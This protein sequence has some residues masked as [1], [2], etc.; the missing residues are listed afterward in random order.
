MDFYQ[1]HFTCPTCKSWCTA[2]S[3]SSPPDHIFS[4]RCAQQN[5]TAHQRL[6]YRCLLCP[7]GGKT[8]TC[9]YSDRFRSN[10]SLTRCHQHYL[11]NIHSPNLQPLPQPAFLSHSNVNTTEQSPS[12]VSLTSMSSNIGIATTNDHNINIDSAQSDSENTAFDGMNIECQ[13]L[14]FGNSS[15]L[16][17]SCTDDQSQDSCNDQNVHFDQSD[18][19]SN[20]AFDDMNIEC[21]GVHFENNSDLNNSC[22]HGASHESCPDSDALHRTYQKVKVSYENNECFQDE[23]AFFEHLKEHTT[24]AT[25]KDV[26]DVYPQLHE[27]HKLRYMEYN[28]HGKNTGSQFMISNSFSRHGND[29]FQILEPVQSLFHVLLSK[30][31]NDLTISQRVNFMAL[32]QYMITEE[33]LGNIPD[34]GTNSLENYWAPGP[35]SILNSLPTPEFLY[36]DSDTGYIYQGIGNLIE[37]LFST[38]HAPKPFVRMSNSFHANSPR[39]NE[40]LV[41]VNDSQRLET[42][43]NNFYNVE[44]TLWADGFAPSNYNSASVHVCLVT[45]GVQEGDHTGRN[46]YILWLGPANQS[47]ISVE[48]QLMAELNNLQQ[49]LKANGVPFRVYHKPSQRIV[50]VRVCLFA[51]LCDKPDKAKR[52]QMLAGGS[53]FHLRHGIMGNFHTE[54]DRIVPCIDCYATLTTIP[55]Q[56]NPDSST[57]NGIHECNKC[58]C[59]NIHRMD[60]EVSEEYPTKFPD[61]CPDRCKPVQGRLK[62]RELTWLNGVMDQT[63]QTAFDGY[64]HSNWTIGEFQMFLRTHCINAEYTSLI[65]DHASNAKELLKV[66]DGTSVVHAGVRERTLASFETNPSYFDVPKAPPLQR[67]G[68]FDLKDFPSGIGHQLFLGVMKSMCKSLLPRFVGAMKSKKAF[69]NELNRKLVAFALPKFQDFPCQDS[70]RDLSFSSYLCKHWVTLCRFSKFFFHHAPTKVPSPEDVALTKKSALPKDETPFRQYNHPQIENWLLRRGVPQKYIPNK[71]AGRRSLFLNWTNNPS[72]LFAKIHVVDDN[73]DFMSD[74]H[75]SAYDKFVNNDC[76]DSFTAQFNAYVNTHTIHPPDLYETVSDDIKPSMLADVISSYLALISR[77]MGPSGD[78]ADPIERYSKIFL[79]KAHELDIFLTPSSSKHKGTL[80]RQPNYLSILN[81]AGEVRRFGH[82]RF[83]WEL[84]GGGEGYIKRIKYKITTLGPNFAKLAATSVMND[85]AFSDIIENLL[86]NEVIANQMLDYSNAEQ[87]SRKL[88]SR[89]QVSHK[90]FD[91][92][93]DNVLEHCPSNG[94]GASA[95]HLKDELLSS[96]GSQLLDSEGNLVKQYSTREV[97]TFFGFK[98]EITSVL[99]HIQTEQ[100]FLVE[101]NTRNKVLSLVEID[102]IKEQSSMLFRFGACYFQVPN[103]PASTTVV[104]KDCSYKCGDFVAGIAFQYDRERSSDLFYFVRRDWTE[105]TFNEQHNCHLHQDNQIGFYNPSTLDVLKKSTVGVTQFQN[106][107]V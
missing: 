88:S 24:I 2:T 41:D 82:L 94:L 9:S 106:E 27:E 43:G 92:A 37:Y 7:I 64:V 59:F 39:G 100:V 54:I 36:E 105:L 5:C 60:F 91:A 65:L 30:F 96:T 61:C 58:K 85:V 78:K 71:P 48:E 31:S 34:H 74:A 81:L 10:H 95:V 75:H 19:D 16:N 63:I 103:K 89:E 104:D 49:G 13:R 35:K 40:L 45:I 3:S 90:L 22:S 52:T 53:T 42:A 1:N 56:D 87:V 20:A 8:L 28:H 77:V 50:H 62:F 107:T 46:T 15:D 80:C 18:N 93:Q 12:L 25:V 21:P 99:I 101:H 55:H 72:D 97:L 51:F 29:G 38:D 66:N 67:I 44:I 47:T 86:H 73:R 17:H 23:E 33:E 4:G 11:G 76:D 102:I 57:L 70:C 79:T 68:G 6:F 83:L 14:H 26:H 32:L 98:S 84:G 69:Q